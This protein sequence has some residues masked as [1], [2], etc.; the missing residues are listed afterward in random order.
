[1]PV[2]PFRHTREIAAP[3]EDV[4]A[5]FADPARH[6]RWWGPDGFRNTFTSRDFRSGGRWVFTMHGPDRRDYAN[7]SVFREVSPS[8]IVIAHES[9]PQYVLT[10]E[11]RPSANGTL[12]SWVQEFETERVA[13]RLETIVR[14]ANEQNLQ[15]LE[16]EVARG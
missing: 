5:A 16:A 11:L 3:P 1:M 10:I 15:R 14:P 2:N 4:Y 13:S 12:V 6:A 7:Q 9:N 8:R